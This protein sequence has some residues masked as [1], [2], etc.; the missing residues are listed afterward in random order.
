MVVGKTLFCAP[1]DAWSVRMIDA[2][3]EEVRHIPCGMDGKD[4]WRSITALGEKLWCAPHHAS[5]VLAIDANPL[6]ARSLSVVRSSGVC[7]SA[8]ETVGN[9]GFPRVIAFC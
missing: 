9:A 7:S 1:Q 2:E 3:T 6:A 8:L 4:K 5:D